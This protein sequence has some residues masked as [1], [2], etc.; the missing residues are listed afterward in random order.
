MK[1]SSILII[2]LLSLSLSGCLKSRMALP[3][4]PAPPPPPARPDVDYTDVREY[5]Y[6]TRSPVPVK[7]KRYEGS[8]WKDESSWGN[9]LRDHRARFRHD[10]VT[11]TDLSEIIVIPKKDPVAAA[12][13]G[14]GAA[15]EA[16]AGQAN[17]ALDAINATLG[18]DNAEDEQN[19]VL[20]N[21]KTI[22]ARVLSVLPNGN[23]VIIGE[24]VDYRRQNSVRYVTNIKG[25]V[26]PEDVNEKNEINSLKMARSE[27][28]IKRQVMAKRLNLGA[29]A[30][31]AGRNSAGLL[32]RLSHMATPGGGKG[33]APVQ[34]K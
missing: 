3:K 26:R 9:L 16:A 30:P 18:L 21:L 28:K 27:V 7:E 29:L 22:S 17:V 15:T 6:R 34:T 8:L 12:G 1:G 20:A 11:I 10:V 14:A 2:L 19:E 33:T 5:S 24:K 13:A 31:I 4:A 23:M 25:V 32:D